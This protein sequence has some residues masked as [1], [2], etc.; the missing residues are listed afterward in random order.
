MHLSRFR[1]NHGL[2]LAFAIQLVLNCSIR[3]PV[4]A[5]D[6]IPAPTV[7]NARNN[8]SFESG[9]LIGTAIDEGNVEIAFDSGN[10]SAA[11]RTAT[12]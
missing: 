4:G 2:T 5:F 9:F 12:K 6:A 7:T 8:A 11:T 10:F 3:A 1:M